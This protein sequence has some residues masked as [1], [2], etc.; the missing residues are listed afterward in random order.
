M[1]ISK[2]SAGKDLPNNVNVIVEIPQGGN[3]I[4]YEFD[5]DAGAILVD[6]I[7]NT[8]MSYPFNYG[9]I[10]HTL[11]E[12]GDPVDVCIIAPYAFVPGSVC[13]VRPIGLLEMEDEAGLDEKII[14]VPD[15]KTYPL[16]KDVQSIDDLPQLVLDQIRHFFEHYKDLEKG[17]WVKL[18]EWRGR[19][20]ALQ[21][22]LDGKKRAK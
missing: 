3:P 8:P 1:D 21:A 15:D 7:V 20:V 16:Y 4:K 19:D 9:F 6:R 10:P 22:I 5:K 13:P 12:D 11:S 18:K 17:K 14:A 2:I